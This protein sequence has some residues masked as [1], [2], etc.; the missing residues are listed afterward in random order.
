M[1]HEGAGCLPGVGRDVYG[2]AA[3]S[4]V[5]TLRCRVTGLGC[6]LPSFDN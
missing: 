3:G 6:R 4:V 1:L 2:L 5:T